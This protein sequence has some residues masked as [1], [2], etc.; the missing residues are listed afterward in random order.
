MSRI[1]LALSCSITLLVSGCA[2][3]PTGPSIMVLPSPGQSFD[4]FRNDD[5]ICQQFANSQMGG[6]SANDA[7]VD[8]G[9]GS[10][11]VGTLLG[12]ALGAA[13]SGGRGAAI[14]AGSGLVA[15]SVM[16]LGASGSSRNATQQRYD[17]AYMQCMYAKGHQVPVSGHISNQSPY[18]SV[19]PY[20]SAPPATNVPPP[21]P[22]L[23]PPAPNQ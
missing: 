23:P 17:A 5:A 10:A 8:S 19:A 1:S 7:A 11:V 2:S 3:I 21:P 6:A 16:G 4:Q 18:P 9:V 12:A 13:V 14:G 15:G 22:G 20:Q